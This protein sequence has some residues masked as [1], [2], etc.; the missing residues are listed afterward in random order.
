MFVNLHRFKKIN[1]SHSEFALRSNSI[2]SFYN[3]EKFITF[4][5][6]LFKIDDILR[7]L[8]CRVLPN[9]VE[10]V[11]FSRALPAG[12]IEQDK[13]CEKSYKYTTGPALPAFFK[14]IRFSPR[15]CHTRSREKSSCVFCDRRVP[16]SG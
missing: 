12:Y 15:Q 11:S 6:F 1:N 9:F 13:S 5:D 10:P 16:L 3:F 8:M 2:I 7:A 4:K 14:P